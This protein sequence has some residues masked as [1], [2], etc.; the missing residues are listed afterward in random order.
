QSRDGKSKE[1]RIRVRHQLVRFFCRGIKRQRMIDIVV[2]GER[3]LTVR[4]VDG[5]RRCEDEM[6][7]AV[8]TAALEDVE[9]SV[10]VARGVRV[11][12][13]E[14]VTDAR[15]RGEMN[16]AFRFELVEEPRRRVAI[17]EID[18]LESKS[19]TRRQQLAQ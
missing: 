6:L 17:G 1:V 3:L 14:R 16:D 12:I 15:L 7:D 10:D 5:A 19:R 2:L 13:D 18:F 9:E 4:A 8:I 11:R